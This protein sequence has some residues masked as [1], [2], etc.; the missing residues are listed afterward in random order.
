MKNIFK[1]II[2]IMSLSLLGFAQ[3]ECPT[4]NPNSQPITSFNTVDTAGN[5]H[6]NV[7]QPLTDYNSA[8]SRPLVLPN[9]GLEAVQVPNATSTGTTNFS[10]AKL[11]GAPSTA[12]IA[13]TTDNKNN[14][15]VGI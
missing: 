12:V 14:S 13:A 6:Q 7:C 9:I 1:F 5:R 8:A 3:T 4:V 15:I 10:F 2:L 11:T